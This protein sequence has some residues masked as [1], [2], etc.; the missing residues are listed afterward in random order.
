VPIITAGLHR[1]VDTDHR[2]T[3]EVCL[4]PTPGHT[5]GH[6]SVRI[7]SGDQSALITGDMVHHPAQIVRHDWPS[8][9]DHDPAVSVST[10][11]AVFADAAERGVL[12]FG[13]HF[14]EPAAGYITR[15]GEGWAWQPQP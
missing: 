10:R 1:F 15:R 7:E 5:P 3:P 8:V 4:V 13:T 6:V 2:I 9:P 12:V 11:R 14:A